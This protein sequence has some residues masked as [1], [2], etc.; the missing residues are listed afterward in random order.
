MSLSS[1][2]LSALSGLRATQSSM[3][4]VANN[5]A[6]ADTPNYTRKVQTPQEV[7][8]G[9]VGTG[10]RA[11]DVSRVL[12]TLVQKQLWTET[13]GG[14]YAATKADY[15][16][17]LDTLFGTPGSSTSLDGIFNAFTQSLQA[18]AATPDSATA[19]T[20]VLG[21]AR[22]LAQQ[23]NSATDTVQSLRSSAE[24]QLAQAVQDAN[25][26]LAGLKSV[27]DRIDRLSGSGQAPAALLDERDGYIAQLSS[28]MDIK[29]ASAGG[30]KI[31]VTT[32]SGAPLFDGEPATLSF[33][34]RGELGARDLY[35]TDPTQRGV[36]TITLTPPGGGA[37]TDMI[38]G[39]QIRSG[40]IGAL[41]ELRDDTLVQ[42]QTQLDTI[43]GQMSLALSNTNV[44]GTAATSGGQ[45]GF[46]L[47]LSG[48]Q[49][50]NPLTVSYSAGGVAKQA[51]FVEVSPDTPLPL[52][53]SANGGASNVTVVGYTGGADGART[54]I[55]ATLGAGFTVSG[56]G[57]SVTVLDDGAA[58]TTDVTGLSAS[59]TSTALSGAGTALPL[60]VDGSGGTLYTGSFDGGLSQRTGLAGRIAVNAGLIADPSLL[61]QYDAGVQTGDA[62]RP[63][64]ILDALTK[65][66]MAF[67]P[68]TGI[69]GTGNPYAGTVGSFTRAVVE[70]QGRA[71]EVAKNLNAGQQVVVNALADKLSASAGVSIDAEMSNLLT[72]QNA[73][74]ANARVMSTIQ[75]MMKTLM[76]M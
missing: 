9:G 54:A 51:V 4:V 29:V 8:S 60:F 69:G 13:A 11:G 2:M 32:A 73:Y 55:A 44:A 53:A 24:A 57:S 76:N 38:A 59:V 47:D 37:A 33:D 23:L 3:G 42:A 15:H 74:A 41:I 56:T 27:S 64:A 35:S 22:A 52:P 48:L 18:L 68:D 40:T 30:N 65:T 34:G 72:L 45:A 19:R 43:A 63:Q 7:V 20:G 46:S 31:T 36:G 14:T 5:V 50:G 25:A 70:A 6:N 28:L 75:D 66:S 1:A 10:V 17:R 62:T 61:V 21:S 26:A 71:G 39:K 58:G 67:Q 49:H 12:D 16:A